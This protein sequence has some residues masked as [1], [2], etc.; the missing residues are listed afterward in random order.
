MLDTEE[1]SMRP[2]WQLRQ[3]KVQKKIERFSK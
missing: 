3:R 1:W 2:A